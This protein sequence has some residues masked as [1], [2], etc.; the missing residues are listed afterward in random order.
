MQ[1]AHRRFFHLQQ[2]SV[3]DVADSADVFVLMTEWHQFRLP[4]W[5]VI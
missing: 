2:E 5:N 3:Y 1:T 4:S